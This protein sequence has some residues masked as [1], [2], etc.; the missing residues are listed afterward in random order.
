MGEDLG[1][2]PMKIVPKIEEGMDRKDVECTTYQMR[3]PFTQF[4]DGVASELDTHCYFQHQYAAS[5][6]KNEDKVL[7]VCCG[8]G[9]LIP[10]IRYATNKP[11]LYV[12]VDIHAKNAT[13]KDG[14]DPR[15]PSQQKTDWGFPLVFVE[16]NVAEM[17]E[18]VNAKLPGILFD[19]IVYTSAIEHMQPE[20][21]RASLAQ[22]R[23]LARDGATMYL[24]CPVH[25]GDGYDCQ[26]AA[27]VYE[28]S[29]GELTEWLDESGW[30][31]NKRIGLCTT[32]TRYKNTLTGGAVVGANAIMKMMPRAQALPTIAALYPACAG[33]VALV[34]TAS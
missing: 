34:C 22:A 30:A 11:S 14:A 17:T 3:N 4:A 21:Q 16:S 33:E 10:F 8:R 28:P 12:G 18:P 1:G 24:T 20:A 7:D 31:I 26:F 5:L 27:H 19:L 9:L 6:M 23:K 2:V 15:R 32:V 13:W 29:I 25:D